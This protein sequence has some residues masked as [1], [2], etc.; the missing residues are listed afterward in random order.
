MARIFNYCASV[1]GA[2][3]RFRARRR[4]HTT[5]EHGIARPK[6]RHYADLAPTMPSNDRDDDDE[7]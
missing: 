2:L 4:E 6:L 1:V 3:T 5:L 7:E